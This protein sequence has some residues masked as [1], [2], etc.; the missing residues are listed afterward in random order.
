MTNYR[1]PW[2]V[3]IFSLG[4]VILEIIVGVPLWMSLP[5]LVPSKTS[6]SYCQKEGLFA[7]KGRIFGEIVKKQRNVIGKLDLI[8]ENENYSKIVPSKGLKK[9]IKGMLEIDFSKRISPQE[10]IDILEK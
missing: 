10:V 7:V 6:S 5:L 2:V 9:V 4:C 8:L 3:D 1:N